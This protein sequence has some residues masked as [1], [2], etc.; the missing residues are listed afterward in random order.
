MD[1]IGF[2]K[3]LIVWGQEHFRPFSWRQTSDPYKIL[4]AEVM[5]HR[6]QAV[7]VSEIYDRFISSYPDILSLNKAT[8]NDLQKTMAPLGLFW[9][10]HL[11]RKMTDSIVEKFECKIPKEKTD[12]LLLPGVSDY[13]ASSVRCFA[14]NLAEPLVDTNTVRVAGRLFNLE[15]KDSSRRNPTI[16]DLITFLLDAEEPRKYNFALLDFADSVCVKRSIPK[17]NM[18]PVK[19]FCILFARSYTAVNVQGASNS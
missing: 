5:L 10:V 2:R 16:R 17:C 7:Q 4:I 18:C 3:K 9:R 12:L 19:E 11:L 6:T 14:W 15:T 1:I 8:Q 13:I